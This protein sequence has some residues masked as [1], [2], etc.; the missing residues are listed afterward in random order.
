M[1]HC[2]TGAHG[3]NKPSY[4]QEELTERVRQLSEET[5][6]RAA[7]APE[8]LSRIENGHANPSIKQIY[9]ICKA[10]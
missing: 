9:W 2:R 8:T 5:E 1:K 7:V 6:S 4:T 10:A 3:R